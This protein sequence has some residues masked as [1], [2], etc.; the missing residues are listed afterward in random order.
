MK[1]MFLALKDIQHAHGRFGLMVA[2]TGLITLLLVMLTGLTGGLGKQ[3]TSALEALGAADDA[4]FVFSSEEPSFTDS[5]F[6]EEAASHYPG[7]QPLGTAQTKLEYKDTA[8]GI[9]LLGLPEGTNVPEGSAT[10]P[11]DGLVISQQIADEVGVAT[12]EWVSVGGV[13]MQIAA[14]TSDLHYSHSPVAWASSESWAKA[15]HAGQ[16]VVGTVLL[17]HDSDLE[18]QAD[19]TVTDT[20]G[21]LKGLAAYQSERSSLMTMQGFLYAISALVTIAF[22]SVWTVQRK[23]DMAVLRALGATS[24]YL[25]KDSLGQAALVLAAGAIAGAVLGLG[26]GMLAQQGVPFNLTSATILIPTVG[27]WL[28]GMLGALLAVRQVKSADP[29]T[30]LGGTA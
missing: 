5:S 2:A 22:L 27:I 11:A 12:G 23:R 21:S 19:H 29:M 26:L 30:V 24:G 18:A 3:N 13:E 28:L 20:K 7:A 15:A 1:A 16:D 17:A 6:T 8:L 10:V 25:F 14:V 4:R 9:G